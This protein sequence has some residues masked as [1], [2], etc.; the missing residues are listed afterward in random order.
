LAWYPVFPFTAIVG[1]EDMKLALLLAA[2]EPGLGGVLIRGEKGTGK[3]TAVRALA[4]LLPEVEVVAGCPCNCDPADP[5]GWCPWCRQGQAVGVFPGVAR[6]PVPVVE[7]PLS[8]TE[9][10][11]VGSLDLEE[12]MRSGRRRF[13]PG[14]LARAHR[15]ILYVDEINLLPD[16][17]VDI[18]LDVAASGVNV[19]EREGISF[20]HPARIILVGTMNPEEGELRPGLLD[21]FGLACEVRGIRDPLLRAALMRRREEFD[22][23]P[24]AFLAACGEREEQVRTRL[25]RARA[26]V[27]QVAAGEDTLERAVQLA[28]EARVAGHRAE[29]TMVQAARAWAAWEGRSEATPADVDRVAP[30]VLAHRQRSP[31]AAPR[32][33]SPERPAEEGGEPEHIHPRP[34]HRDPGHGSSAGSRGLG[35]DRTGSPDV[36]GLSPA[37]A[38]FSSSGR[39][40]VFGVGE[41]FTP[42]RIEHGRDRRCRRA[43]GRRSRSYT[44]Q[45]AGRYVRAILPRGTGDL[46]LDAILRTAAPRQAGRSRPGLAVVVEADDLREKWRERRVRNLLLFVV[47]ASGSMGV[48]QRMVAAKGAVL[49]L[50]LDAYR[51][52]D[53]V[54]MVA[55][56]Q[57]GAQLVLPP[58][59]SV[60][61]ARK[62]LADLPTGGRTPLAAGLLEAYRLVRDHLQRRSGILPL[63]IILTDG[64]ANVGLGGGDP[65]E[66]ARKVA[67][68]FRRDP[69]VDVLVVDVERPG[70][71][72]FGLA[73]QVA[74]ALGA[75]YARVDELSAG[76]LAR[77]VT[78]WVKWGE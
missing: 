1:Q 14:L 15:G 41:P 49:S 46:A 16:H 57:N 23:D 36:E 32:P 71:V 27:R 39:G 55:F 62:R 3:S 18:L 10:R 47:D 2:I 20:S 67:H 66:D 65:V 70:M 74:Q 48:E 69:R 24:R 59:R 63:C 35:A 78:Q 30:F 9:D 68:L 8:A 53:L 11:V 25:A 13:E 43:T 42:R 54:A 52:R 38:A 77:R 17:L 73:R 34:E 37:E 22:A 45:K 51:R 21:R 33:P 6:R 19:V 58:T 26:L 75:A 12:A 76:S 40:Q 72:S 56:R 5:S 4:A 44:D 60:E 50:L 7:L 29:I 31:A 64:R 28:C 61:V